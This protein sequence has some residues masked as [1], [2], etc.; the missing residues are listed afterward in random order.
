MIVVHGVYNP[1]S[2]VRSTDQLAEDLRDEGYEV[3]ELSWSYHDP[4]SIA[5]VRFQIMMANSDTFVIG[6]SFGGI[7]TSST[8]TR[9]KTIE[10]NTLFSNEVKGD[11]DWLSKFD[12]QGETVEGGHT[13]DENITLEIIRQIQN[14]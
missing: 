13:I 5:N 2:D 1:F 10:V 12:P 11:K 7:L 4:T 3:E 8:P 6:H 14:G 9:A